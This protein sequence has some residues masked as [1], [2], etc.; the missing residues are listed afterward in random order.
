M[1]RITKYKNLI[2]YSLAFLIPIAFLLLS[3]IPSGIFPF[4]NHQFIYWDNENE[5][6]HF[7]SYLKHVLTSND[8]IFYS[9]SNTGGNEMLSFSAYYLM[10][11]LNLIT[12]L[13]PTKN[14]NIAIEIIM[15]LKIGFCG[16][17]F[18]YFLNNAFLSRYINI[19]F[20]VTYALSSYNLMNI[21]NLMFFDGIALLPIVILGLIKIFKNNNKYLTYIISLS[22]ITI[23][24]IFIGYVA[25]LFSFLFFIYLIL[26][27][28]IVKNKKIKEL[29]KTIRTYILSTFLS[30]GLCAFWLI[31]VI[32]STTNTKYSLF[33]LTN[34]IFAL[35]MNV[36]EFITKTLTGTFEEGLFYN[37]K[38]PHI[39]IGILGL[40]LVCL[41]FANK[42][43]SKKERLLDGSFLIFLASCFTLNIL[44]TIFNMGVENPS[45]T[46][47]RFGFIFIFF[48]TYLAYKSFININKIDYRNIFYVCII[49][50]FIILYAFYK[51]TDFISI[52]L[53]YLFIDIIL[54]LI[55]IG[56]ITRIINNKPISGKKLS[57]IFALIFSVHFLNLFI[58]T[59]Y[60]I[61]S[62]RNCHINNSNSA[63]S[64]LYDR[65]YP[66]LEFIK[67]K[68]ENNNSIYRIETDINNLNREDFFDTLINSSFSFN[69]NSLSGFVT[70]INT[71][72]INFYKTIGVLMDDRQFVLT[73]SKD[74][75][76]FPLSLM[77]LKKII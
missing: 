27:E 44:F 67:S 43:I 37:A 56:L 51:R 26:N 14:I 15:I 47:Y 58:N 25:Y 5:S 20:A 71:N 36:F 24:H 38:S 46:F 69:L 61:R 73:Y 63:F 55:F 72:K 29:Y 32:K 17:F 52:H 30:L 74:T 68:E 6:V 2:I 4:G 23:T 10:S 21:S 60:A 75:I 13:F 48:I 77:G 9:L 59:E 40:I 50:S 28:L 35:R 19:A 1:H 41:Y 53:P 45:G 54:L 7:F 65:I 33:S 3:L 22:I 11:L 34:H 62:Q 18:A 57:T 8:N 70:T 64:E 49:F 42:N 76:V 16:L 39:F 31:P 66:A 12:L